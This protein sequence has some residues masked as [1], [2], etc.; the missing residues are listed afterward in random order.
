[1]F[2][3]GCLGPEGRA[4]VRGTE[5]QSEEVAWLEEAEGGRI[6]KHKRRK[7]H[8]RRWQQRRRGQPQGFAFAQ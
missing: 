1:M 8:V 5:E 7:R 3:A 2:E 4:P 6:G